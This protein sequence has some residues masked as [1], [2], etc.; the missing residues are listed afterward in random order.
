MMLTDEVIAID[1]DWLPSEFFEPIGW[2]LNASSVVTGA[3]LGSMADLLD[4]HTLCL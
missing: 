2:N 1:A 3:A 4:G